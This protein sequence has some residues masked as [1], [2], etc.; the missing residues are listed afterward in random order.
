MK[1]PISLRGTKKETRY[2]LYGFSFDMAQPYH[3]RS[4]NFLHFKEIFSF[5]LFELYDL[6]WVQLKCRIEFI[7]III[8]PIVKCYILF[9]NVLRVS[10]MSMVS[11]SQ[12]VIFKNVYYIKGN[13]SNKLGW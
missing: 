11:G 2:T 9:L 4:L 3:L 13:L 7:R 12:N 6:T 5:C 1:T 10:I 8:G